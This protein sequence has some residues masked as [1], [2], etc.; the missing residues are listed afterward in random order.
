MIDPALVFD[1]LLAVTLPLLAWFIFAA[2]D[3]FQS[4]VLFIVLGLLIALAYVRMNA[5]DVALAE[6][7][8]GAGLTGA[9]LLNTL[10]F[11]SRRAAPSA[12]SSMAHEAEPHERP[13]ADSGL[14]QQVIRLPRA[15][16]PLSLGAMLI[17]VVLMLPAPTIDIPAQ[18]QRELPNSGASNPVTAVLL[19]FRNYDTLLEVG[20]L[21][22][23]VIGVWSLRLNPTPVRRPW[24]DDRVL[25]ALVRLLAP[26]MIVVSGYLLWAGS[27]R[28]SGA[29]Q[30]GAVL[31]AI[32]ELL[33][34]A[35]VFH[36]VIR[37]G[38]PIRL[39]LAAGFGVFIAVAVAMLAAGGTLL[40][41]PSGSATFLI[42]LVE[43]MLTISIGWTLALLLWG[44]EPTSAP[45]Q[46]LN[47]E[48][49]T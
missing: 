13:R 18:V 21:L 23:S 33:L 49:S 42:L 22:L 40:E 14:R 37:R 9:L 2:R 1:T 11:V 47:K 39:A 36:I 27:S 46:P 3:L 29:F 6:A 43:T 5:P 15:V 24:A 45:D 48:A 35:A 44:A 17:V 8:I 4:V 30:A 41:Y 19:N 7:A 10:G 34:L 31:A 28:P 25:H 32:G 12:S 16:L 38:W 20:V 26:V